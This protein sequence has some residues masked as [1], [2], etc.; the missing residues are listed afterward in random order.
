MKL[1][2]KTRKGKNKIHEAGTDEWQIARGPEPCICFNG[3]MGIMIEP[4]TG[5]QANKSR[6]ILADNDPDFEWA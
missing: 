6:W 5:D 1:V 3:A 2:G 4:M